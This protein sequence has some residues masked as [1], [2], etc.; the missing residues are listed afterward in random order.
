M[1]LPRRAAHDRA[2]DHR[3]RRRR[4]RRRV[5]PLLKGLPPLLD[6]LVAIVGVGL[7]ATFDHALDAAR[8]VFAHTPQRRR[9]L[10]DLRH[11]DRSHGVVREGDL[12]GQELVEDDGGRV[13]VGPL[14]G[15]ACRLRPGLLGRHVPGCARRD[16]VCLGRF[17][18]AGDAEVGQHQLLAATGAAAPPEQ[19][20]ARLEVA[21]DHAG[22]VGH[23]QA[24]GDGH[25]EVDRLV[26]VVGLLVAGARLHAR[27]ERAPV[28]EVHDEVGP[29]VGQLAHGVDTDDVIVV[30]LPE[31]PRFLFEATLDLIVVAPVVGQHLGGHVRVEP[32]VA[33]E[34][35]RG[36]AP[37]A[38]PSLHD[39]GPDEVRHL[40]QPAPSP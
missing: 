31:D 32:V 26:D 17:E 4:D 20:V 30:E 34:P 39:V 35:D 37:A 15:L 11:D 1:C 25:R 40:H 28:G 29:S 36:E 5:A 33:D 2:L 23:G 7:E 27:L 38:Q 19:H 21:V 9:A 13:D 10:A 24:V 14:V 18:L 16:G 6:R 12:P 22:V 3:G 8:H